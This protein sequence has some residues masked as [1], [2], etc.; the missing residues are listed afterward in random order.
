MQKGK[1]KKLIVINSVLALLLICGFV[2]AWFASQYVNEVTSNDVTV[3]ADNAIELSLDQTKW[4]NSLNLSNDLTGFKDVTYK[5]ITGSGEGS[6]LRPDLAQFS[7]HAE[8]SGDNTWS[9]TPVAQKDYVEFTLYM[10]ATTNMD[11][12][13]GN[14][15][16][17]LPSVGMDYLLGPNAKNLSPY[18]TSTTK[19][20]KDLAVGAARV[21]V[22]NSSSSRL[23]TWIPR[24]EIYFSTT[25][26][27]YSN[28][29]DIKTNSTSGES[30]EHTYY[31]NKT[32][33]SP[34][35][36]TTSVITGDISATNTQKLATL[37]KPN[38]SDYYEGNVTIYIWLEG[39]DKEARRAFVGGNFKVT[40]NITAQDNV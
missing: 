25:D 5:D 31:A 6:F 38:G 11:V 14:G 23:F 4:T 40:L 10:R 27:S 36:L 8:I 30:Y 39:C 29:D 13:L 19:F 34:T 1:K 20:S 21:S 16:N 28:Y 15:S 22:V 12:Y 17:V 37:T 9:E 2:Y 26:A 7:D 35:K 33:T 24:P 18:S 3:V 32:D